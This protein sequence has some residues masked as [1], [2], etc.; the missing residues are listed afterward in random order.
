[1]YA[2]VCFPFFISKTFTYKVPN[3]LV[4]SLQSGDLVEVKFKHKLCKG[5]VAS[6]SSTIS[7]KGQLNSILSIDDTNKIPHDLWQT[8]LW[9]SNYYVTPIGKITQTTLSWAFKDNTIKNKSII[10]NNHD[11]DI[12]SINSLILTSTQNHVYNQIN[13]F[14]SKDQKPQF[15]Y[16]IPGSGKTEIYLKLTQNFLSKNKSCLILIP[17]IALS[18]QIFSRFKQYFGEK[19]LL[20]HSQASDS[21]KKKVLNKLKENTCYIIIGARSALFTPLNNLGLIIVDEEHDSSYKEAERQPCYNARDL[22]IIR[23]KYSNSLVLLGSATPSLETYYNSIIL[24][25]YHLHEINER[26]GDAKLPQ[27]KI[28]DMN[29]NK[30]IK[31]DQKLLSKYLINKINIVLQKDEQILILHNRRGFSSIKICTES[32]EILKCKNCDV[33]LTFHARLNQLIC[34]HC[35]Q[36]YLFDEYT[37]QDISFL[38]YGTEQLE[39]ILN[40]LFPEAGVLRMDSDSASSMKKKKDILNQ[41]KNKEYNI[42]LGTQMIAKGLDFSNITLVAV[43]NAELGMSIPDFKSHEKMFQLLYQVIGRSGRSHKIGQAIIQ[44]YQPDNALI[45]MA[46]HYQSKKFYNLNLESRKSLQYP[47]FVRLVRLLFQSKNINQCINSANKIY[48]L[49]KIDFSENIIGPLPC[50]IERLAN[51]S[52]YHILLKIKPNKLKSSL[53]KIKAI[54]DNKES[55]ISKNVKLLIDV[56]SISVL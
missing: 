23:A 19:V 32:D 1:M 11:Y 47:P 56:D 16:G 13:H 22:A 36:K 28:I 37:K 7:F 14:F 18:S 45:Q 52:R 30:K 42:L 9:M 2:Q 54:Q 40:Q 35:N 43:I 24:N 26:Y 12:I 31:A 6:L 33:I 27:V 55:L 15:L 3:Q 10:D 46:T 38:G 17:E 53:K 8:L 39:T 34:H 29:E 49:L 50:P 5:F 20:W 41:F 21:Y 4:N 25:K 51:R 48:N 44:T